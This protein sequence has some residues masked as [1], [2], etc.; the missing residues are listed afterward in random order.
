MKQP[1]QIT[2]R[3]LLKQAAAAGVGA[4]AL[5]QIVPSSVFGATPPARN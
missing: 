4:V 3:T 1:S 2:R 5:P